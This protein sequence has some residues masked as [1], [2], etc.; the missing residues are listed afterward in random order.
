MEK[1]CIRLFCQYLL[2]VLFG[3]E[4]KGITAWR[5]RADL[6]SFTHQ[7]RA[8]EHLLDISFLTAALLFDG[9]QLRSFS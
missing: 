7:S 4:E 5:G 6:E 1:S 2:E 8:E 3:A 9:L